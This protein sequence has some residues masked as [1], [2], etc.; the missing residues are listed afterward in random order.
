MYIYIYI[1]QMGPTDTPDS[2]FSSG[3][4]CSQESKA[5]GS[6]R[7]DCSTISISISISITIIITIISACLCTLS[8]LEDMNF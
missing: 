8:L 7:G 6:G 1:V 4:A 2:C 5:P 3:K